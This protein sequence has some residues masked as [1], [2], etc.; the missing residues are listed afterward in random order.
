MKESQGSDAQRS[1]S[2]P[3][4]QADSAPA[5]QTAA[6]PSSSQDLLQQ[7]REANEQLVDSAIRAKEAHEAADLRFRDLVEGLDAIVWEAD[8]DTGRFTFVSQ[9]AETILGYPSRRWTEEPDFWPTVIHPEDR[10]Q[11]LKSCKSALEARQNYQLEFRTVAADGRIVWVSQR[12][13]LKS[14]VSH[15]T[16]ALGFMVDISE[17]KRTEER[18]QQVVRDY[19]ASEK[20][21]RE[22]LDELEQF[23]EVV[24]G[25]ELKMIELEKEIERLKRELE[26]LRTTRERAR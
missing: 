19:Q 16:R 1:E 13:H 21:L 6:E 4:G 18:L 17:R 22:K 15:P 23:E 20:T 8:A 7:I 14:A 5:G 2:D 26:T 9:Q 12:A 11:T 3:A 10:D 25:R 24:V